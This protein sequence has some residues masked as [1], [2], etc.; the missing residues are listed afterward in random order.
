MRAC[1]D[2]DSAISVLKVH[3]H[4]AMYM[5]GTESQGQT[6]QQVQHVCVSAVCVLQLVAVAHHHTVLCQSFLTPSW[7]CHSSTES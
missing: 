1:S 4:H 6:H 7:G 5:C 3:L 2:V